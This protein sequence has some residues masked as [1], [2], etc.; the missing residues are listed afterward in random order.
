MGKWAVLAAV[1]VSGC[2]ATGPWQSVNLATKA[3][4]VRDCKRLGRVKATVRGSK[5]DTTDDLRM[6]AWMKDATDVAVIGQGHNAWTFGF[7][8]WWQGGV[9]Y[10]LFAVAYDCNNRK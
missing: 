2:A 5:K 10:Y 1:L 9:N 6:E 8:P 7:W 4:E 3:S